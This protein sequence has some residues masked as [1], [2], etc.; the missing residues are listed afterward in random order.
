MTRKKI[1]T[2]VY[3]FGNPGRED[4]GLGDAMIKRL[5]TWVKDNYILDVD[6][7]SNYQLNVEDAE[8]ISNYQR[9]IFVDASKEDIKVCK[10]EKLKP[11]K[12]TIEFTMHAVSPSYLIYLARELFHKSPECY[13]L[14]IRGKYWTIKEGIS[15]DASMNLDKTEL[16]LR[17]I[18]RESIFKKSICHI[19]ED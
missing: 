18:L 1:K 3:G 6:L 13:L 2:L 19:F 12:K 4:D 14:S 11:A 17:P 9:V 5:Q 7:E 10:I 16:F 8:M 15:I